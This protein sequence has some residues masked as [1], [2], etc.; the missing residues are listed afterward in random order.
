M[1]HIMET[2]FIMARI[3]NNNHKSQVND[4]VFFSALALAPLSV[5]TRKQ[6]ELIYGLL[7]AL[8]PSFTA[9]T[10]KWKRFNCSTISLL[11]QIHFFFFR[12][13]VQTINDEVRPGRVTLRFVKSRS[14]F[15]IFSSA[16]NLLHVLQ[17]ALFAIHSLIEKDQKV[18]FRK[19]WQV[20]SSIVNLCTFL[21]LL[22]AQI[23]WQ[24]LLGLTQC[25]GACEKGSSLIVFSTI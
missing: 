16:L 19:V 11:T 25:V 2:W 6:G 20:C 12:W 15:F 3:G 17:L 5:S 22:M 8:H 14:R 24:E 13:C 21:C 18:C 1:R 4:A 10:P 23:Y 9:W 7:V